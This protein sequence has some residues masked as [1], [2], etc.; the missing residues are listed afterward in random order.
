[1]YKCLL[2]SPEELLEATPDKHRAA[3]AAVK[4]G[5]RGM[6]AALVDRHWDGMSD[7]E[8]GRVLVAGAKAKGVTGCRDDC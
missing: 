2:P 4:A 1:M 6:V 5:K 7:D 8:K 3:S